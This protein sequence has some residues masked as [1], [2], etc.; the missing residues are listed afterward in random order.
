M[1]VKQSVTWATIINLLLIK[2]VA[3]W[4][5]YLFKSVVSWNKKQPTNHRVP[6]AH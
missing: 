3:F 6:S 5:D 2:A 1:L 4:P